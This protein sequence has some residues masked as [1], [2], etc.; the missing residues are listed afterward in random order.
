MKNLKYILFSFLLA[1]TWLT[2]HAQIYAYHFPTYHAE[3]NSFNKM[4]SINQ[5]DGVGIQLSHFDKYPLVKNIFSAPVI[6]SSENVDHF[7]LP[8]NYDYEC[9][10]SLIDAEGLLFQVFVSVKYDLP[11]APDEIPYYYLNDSH[12]EMKNGGYIDETTHPNIYRTFKKKKSDD[13]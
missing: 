6:A 7:E 5:A 4:D 8:S 3:V 2:S 11:Y 13:N 1:T 9:D 10:F 12:S